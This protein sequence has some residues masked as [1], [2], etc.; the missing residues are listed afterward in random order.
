M[1]N[2]NEPYFIAEIGQNHQ[3]DINIAKKMVDALVGTGVSCIKTA[4]RDIDTCLS[5]TQKGMPYINENS[6]GDTY[7]EHRKAL[8]LSK[9]EFLELEEYVKSRG[10]DF[11]S[12][13][14]DIPSLEFLVNDCDLKFLKIASQ[15]MADIPL[16]EAAAKTGKP[17]IISTGMCTIGDVDEAVNNIFKDND[18]YLMQCTSSYPCEDRDINLNVL[19]T[20]QERYAGKIKAFGLSGHHMSISPDLAAYVMGANIIER[21]FTLDRNMRGTDHK[22]SLEV[23][24]VKLITKYIRQIHTAMGSFDKEI[25]KSEL[26]ALKK[27]RG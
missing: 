3:G 12:S 14:T 11:T 24:G 8:E 20:Y 6:F 21:H 17:I 22:G 16:L 19:K 13:F 4:K 9:D 27:L 2:P 15:R 1:I 26:P 23:D 5:E 25:L 18:K 7:Y 10:F